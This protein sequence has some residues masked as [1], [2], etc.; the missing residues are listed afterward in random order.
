[1]NESKF[2]NND[3]SISNNDKRV[4]CSENKRISNKGNAFAT[5]KAR[6]TVFLCLFLFLPMAQFIVFYFGVNLRSILLAFQTYD[7]AE[8]TFKFT[9]FENFG[10]VI[11]DFFVNKSLLPALKNSLYMFLLNIVSI[12]LHVVV[13]YAIFRKIPCSNI[14]KVILFVPN[15]VSSVVF[16]ICTRELLTKG[17]PVLFNDASIELLNPYTETSFYTVLWFGFWL[18]FAGG[19][20][21]FLSSMA[22]MPYDVIEYDK[23]ENMNSLQELIYVVIPLIFPTITTYIVVGLAGFFVNYGHL[24]S[25]FGASNENKLYDTVGLVFFVRIIKADTGSDVQMMYPYAAA[26]GLIFTAITA[27]ITIL[28][29]TLLEKYGPSED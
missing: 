27:P 15:I 12:P 8:T 5:M 29:K 6:Q 19:L 1:M 20:V 4:G 25:F 17:I 23:L 18:G 13:A 3:K 24:F 26:G 11:A 10:N 16:I 22:S 9:G 2:N 28:T 14:F 7:L 21:V